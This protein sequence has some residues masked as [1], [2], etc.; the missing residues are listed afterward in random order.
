MP[1]L[2]SSSEKLGCYVQELGLPKL[3]HAF[4]FLLIVTASALKAEAAPP[5]SAC[6]GGVQAALA[7]RMQNIQTYSLKTEVNTPHGIATSYIE[8]RAPNL[9]KISMAEG[10]QPYTYFTTVFDGNFQWLETRVEEEVSVLKVTLQE[11]TSKERPFDT[12]L[13]LHGSG[14]LSGENFPS[15]ITT[16][17]TIYELE[18]KCIDSIISLSGRIRTDRFLNILLR[19]Y[20]ILR[21]RRYQSDL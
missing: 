1:G 18:E 7:E 13:A 19:T 15:T 21:Q 12:S 16:L 8:G 9:L 10:T 4:S 6:A 14:L 11:V 3:H 17:L 20:S 2:A 5:A